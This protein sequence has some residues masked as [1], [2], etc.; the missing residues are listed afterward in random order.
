MDY[1]FKHQVN[2]IKFPKGFE[3]ENRGLKGCC[4]AELVVAETSGTD[5]YKNDVSGVYVKKNENSDVVTFTLEKCGTGVVTNLGTDA[6][7]PNEPMAV[8]YVF[9]WQQIL[10]AYGVGTYEIKV[11]F[12]IAGVTGGYTHSKYELKPYQRDTV[13]HTV[14][15]HTKFNSYFLKDKIDFTGS[16]F[17]DSVRFCGIFGKRQPK[18]EINNLIGTGRNVQKVTR[19]NLNSYELLTDPIDINI[20]RKLLDLHFLCE[21]EMLISD[22]NQKN[23]DYLLFDKKA[24]LI[25]SPEVEYYTGNRAAKITA[26]LGDKDLLDK[27]YYRTY[28]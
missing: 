26:I 8:G 16:N 3:E 11:Q 17:V 21:D 5:I 12:T 7:F 6:V 22:Y 13:N 2:I 20:S 10:N 25:E 24:V 15:V 9:E 19:E 1:R 18:T 23:H 4:A 28:Y 27:S 14:K